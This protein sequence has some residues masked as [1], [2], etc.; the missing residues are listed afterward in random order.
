MCQNRSFQVKI[1]VSSRDVEELILQNGQE[2]V[3]GNLRIN[4]SQKYDGVVVCSAATSKQRMR[5]RQCQSSSC[6]IVW[7]E[8]LRVVVLPTKTL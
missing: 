2:F 1:P 8:E 6:L 5:V 7:N 3:V 4:L